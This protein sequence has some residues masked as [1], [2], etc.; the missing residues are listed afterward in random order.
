MEGKVKRSFS[1]YFFT[2]RYLYVSPVVGL[3]PVLGA[4]LL[5]VL[6]E[7][8]PDYLAYRRVVPAGVLL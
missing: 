6:Y 2:K 8:L 3:V 4:L 7:G 5:K 1:R